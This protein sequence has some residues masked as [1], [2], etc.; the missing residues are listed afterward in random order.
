M[1]MLAPSSDHLD[2]AIEIALANQRRLPI[3]GGDDVYSPD[4]INQGKDSVAGMIV[5]VAWDIEANSSNSSF[6]GRS[7]NM[8]GTPNVNWRTITAYDAVQ[9]LMSAI[10][11]Q[12]E[13]TR[14][15]VRKEL[16]SSNFFTPGAIERVQFD[17]SGDYRGDIQLVEIQKLGSG[18]DFIPLDTE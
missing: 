7:K 13:P 15:G 8:W 4:T 18:Y 17:E 11:K 9:A 16:S 5:A 12:S 1:I 2:K 10:E 3:I 14:E 6:S